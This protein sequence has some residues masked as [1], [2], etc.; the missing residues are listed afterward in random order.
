MSIL[1]ILIIAII[2]F[3]FL[4]GIAPIIFVLWLG[5]VAYEKGHVWIT[6]ELPE[7]SQSQN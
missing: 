4:K 2:A 1:V 5:A 7:Q 6:G 3:K